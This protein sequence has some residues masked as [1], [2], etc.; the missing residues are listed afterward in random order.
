MAE[1]R[2]NLIIDSCCDL[3]YDLVQ[4]FGVEVL[5][6]PF[7]LSDG[8]HVDDFWQSM[9]YEDFYGMM[10]ADTERPTT[11]Q[12]P[13]SDIK[14]MLVKAA[15][16]DKPTVMLCF[17]AALS[18]TFNTIV[19][20]IE[21]LSSKYPSAEIYAVDCRLASIAEGFLVLETIKQ[22]DAGLSAKEMFEWIKEA[23]NFVHGYFTVDDL[24]YLRRGGRIPSIVAAAGSKLDIKPILTFSEDG[25][26]VIHSMVRGRKK[27]LRTIA[28]LMSENII[29]ASRSQI[30]IGNA[31][32]VEDMKAVEE[33]YRGIPV[34]FLE[35]K[36]GPVIG[37]HV[38]PGMVAAVCWGPDRR[39]GAPAD[40]MPPI[41]LAF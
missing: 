19:N 15:K 14:D 3:P 24:E 34:D 40:S 31:L 2:C 32:A 36:I 12:I 13:I 37:S 7:E 20:E 11:A 25:H 38:G 10:A 41:N 6:F 33:L 23:R 27:A 1:R 5:L 39:K 28:N 4:E 9:S 8:R 17:T 21:N 30:V 29:G 16:S 35:C 18:G 26:L 22:L